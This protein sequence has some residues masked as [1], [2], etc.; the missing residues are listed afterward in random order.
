MIRATLVL[1][2]LLS[3]CFSGADFREC[4]TDGDPCGN[5]G[6]CQAGACVLPGAPLGGAG[7]EGGEGAGVGSGGEGG[8]LG[9]GGAGGGEPIEVDSV[10]DLPRETADQHLI[11]NRA[12][13]QSG[14]ITIEA[15]IIDLQA[16]L[17]ADGLGVRGGDGGDGGAGARNGGSPGNGRSGAGVIMTPGG[18]GGTAAQSVGLPG[19]SASLPVTCSAFDPDMSFPQQGVGGTGAGGGRGGTATGCIGPGG[20]GGGAGGPGG[21]AIYLKASEEI[22]IRGTLS[23]RGEAGGDGGEPGGAACDDCDTCDAQAGRGGPGA[24]D[25]RGGSGASGGGDAGHG[26]VGG[27]G[28]GGMIVLDAPRIQFVNNPAL[29][30]SGGNTSPETGGLVFLRGDISGAFEV[31]GTHP[32]GDCARP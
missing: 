32:D 9:T 20:G 14:S 15:R 6:V 13:S 27:A 26:G 10:D 2:G 1:T 3:G 23:A 5:G 12:A 7:G 22:I 18:A 11:I 19:E 30:V 17:R 25:P 16:G 21:G 28:S 4:P 31:V 24:T 8:G 29:N